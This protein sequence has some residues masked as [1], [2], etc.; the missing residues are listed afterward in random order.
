MGNSNLI[1]KRNTFIQKTRDEIHRT[2]IK[3]LYHY[4]ENFDMKRGPKSKILFL[5]E[6]EIMKRESNT[7]DLDINKDTNLLLECIELLNPHN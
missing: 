6:D 5:L 1:R 3:T 4:R 7:Q 2:P